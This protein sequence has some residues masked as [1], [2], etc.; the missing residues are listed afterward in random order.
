M[1]LE[2]N[3]LTEVSGLRHA[4]KLEILDLSY[5]QITILKG[6]NRLLYLD[7][8]FLNDNQ[9]T[10]LNRLPSNLHD[11][12]INN[13]PGIQDLE[14]ISRLAYIRELYAEN[15]GLS[16]LTLIKNLKYIRVL[17]LNQNPIQEIRY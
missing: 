4:H 8:L 7:S 1:K 12:N 3:N 15:V 11:L 17:Y 10:K 14:Q 2:G 16:D 13:N 5:N 9:I 6:L